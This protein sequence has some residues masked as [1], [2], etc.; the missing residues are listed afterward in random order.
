MSNLSFDL[1]GCVFSRSSSCRSKLPDSV[2]LTVE[3]DANFALPGLASQPMQEICELSEFLDQ[4]VGSYVGVD[5]HRP[6]PHDSP[7]RLV[8]PTPFDRWQDG[9]ATPDR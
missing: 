8:I 9:Y 6:F 2:E 5:Q 1:V 3:F 4:G 7:R